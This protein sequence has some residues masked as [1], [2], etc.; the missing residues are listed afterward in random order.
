VVVDQH[1]V[2]S[3]NYLGTDLVRQL[4]SRGFR[5]M[6]C[7]RSADDSSED[8]TLYARAGAHCSFGKDLLGQDVMEQLKYTYVQLQRA[9]Q[10]P[11]TSPSDMEISPSMGD[12]PASVV[13]AA[14]TDL[15]SP[16]SAFP[17]PD[18]CILHGNQLETHFSPSW[19]PEAVHLFADSS[20][21]LSNPFP[22]QRATRLTMPGYIGDDLR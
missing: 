1:L 12:R 13:T 19:S 14:P 4:L 6:M 20:N 18:P 11:Q 10:L 17:A 15:S 3:Q 8:A 22:F 7:I 16:N 2:Y 9:G 21:T 5:G